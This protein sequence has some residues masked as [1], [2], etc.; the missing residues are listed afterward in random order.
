MRP[1]LNEAERFLT[2]LDEGAEGF[3]FQTFDDS[4]QKRPHLI[5]VKHGT[6]EQHAD[7]LME[8]N[9]QGAGIFVTINQTTLNGRRTGDNIVAVRSVFVDLDGAPLS[10]VLASVDT[11]DLVIE[12]SPSKWHCYWL[13]DCPLDRFEAI[14]KAL[15]VK[16]NSDGKVCDLNRVMRLPGF[17]HQKAA[18]FMVRI[19]D[20]HDG[21]CWSIKRPW[22][23]FAKSM[24]LEFGAAP[25]A[26]TSHKLTKSERFNKRTANDPIVQRLRELG[27]IRSEYPA[28]GK[29]GIECPFKG[30]H[31]SDTGDRE[32]VLFLA[33]YNGFMESRISCFHDHCDGRTQNDFLEALGLGETA[34]NDA[35]PLARFVEF[36][37]TNLRPQ[38]FVLDDLIVSGV[39]LIG[40]SA[41][42]GKTT[43]IVPTMCRAA[44]LCRVD[45]PLKPLLRR[46]V[47]YVA[48]DA[49]Q[50]EHVLASMHASGEFSD[51]TMADVRDRF[52]I[53]EAKR[54]DASEIVRVRSAYEALA[55]E[56]IGH[57]TG[58]IFDAR[59]VVVFD[60]AAATINLENENDNAEVSRSVALIKQ[61]F[62]G[63]S[64]VIVAHLAK[65]LKRADVGNL[66]ARGA[67]AWEGDVNQVC[68]LTHYDDDEP[69]KRWL[70]IRGAKHRFVAKADGLRFSLV[71]NTY[72]GLDILGND[73]WTTIVHGSPE[74][75]TEGERDGLKAQKA[76]DQRDGELLSLRLQ[77]ADKLRKLTA[78]DGYATKNEL[79]LAVGGKRVTVWRQVDAMLEEEAISEREIA[80]EERRSPNH[81][82]GLFA[83]TDGGEHVPDDFHTDDE[84]EAA[85]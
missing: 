32:T 11:P 70:E 26:G 42:V 68:Y 43:A 58:V 83:I 60:T 13:A 28:D 80:K 56:N 44:H 69:N 62:S 55:V 3:T 64:V 31:G 7:A 8:L 57:E 50:V 37:L 30:E 78:R 77:I 17:Y 47:V 36:D 16:F 4:D 48:E 40:G 75:S 27:A 22:Q 29:L 49:L 73:K 33:G 6:I 19:V 23:E 12:T 41:G 74:L 20:E 15:A 5:S 67:N 71:R 21:S 9:R 34:G 24:G 76:A 10:P 82:R 45:D 84:M 81:K 65:A 2:Y 72:S 61:E 63:V 14:Q 35:H 79:C 1:N 51:F 25:G 59:P 54:L 18:P 39:V 85:I 52:K 46:R 38:E 66:S 53:V